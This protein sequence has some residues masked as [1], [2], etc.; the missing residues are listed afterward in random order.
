MIRQ[1]YFITVGINVGR[2][3]LGIFES[4]VKVSNIVNYVNHFLHE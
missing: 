2:I 3:F 4:K 1:T